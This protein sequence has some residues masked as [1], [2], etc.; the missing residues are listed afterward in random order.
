MSTLNHQSSPQ[1]GGST[2][3]KR[4]RSSSLSS[5]SSSSSDVVI[6]LD[7]TETETETGEP[8]KPAPPQQSKSTPVSSDKSQGDDESKILDELR[9]ARDV[10]QMHRNQ[11]AADATSSGGTT[12]A[13]TNE[14]EI[15]YIPGLVNRVMTESNRE[16]GLKRSVVVTEL[17]VELVLGFVE[18]F[19]MQ[20]SK[21]RLSLIHI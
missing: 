6:I 10:L 14:K 8:S 20:M 5:S 16:G 2:S 17:L 11:G 1:S 18:P 13:T 15:E 7:N 4:R 9:Q 21:E 3:R 19:V 12:H